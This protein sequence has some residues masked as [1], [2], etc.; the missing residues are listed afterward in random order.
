M[1]FI[2]K[3]VYPFKIRS[4]HF[5]STS[6]ELNIEVETFIYL[7]VLLARCVTF[8]FCSTNWC[9]FFFSSWLYTKHGNT[10]CYA[11]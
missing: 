6:K 5:Q 2:L 7:S 8:L 1:T 4:Q 9:M 11:T 3:A 10:Q